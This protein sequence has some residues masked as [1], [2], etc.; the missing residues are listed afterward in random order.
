MSLFFIGDLNVLKNKRLSSIDKIVYFTLV[1]YMSRET[2]KCYPRYA[3]IKKDTGISY[4]S[5]QRSVQNLAKQKLLT[6]K[7]LS[8]TNLYLLTEQMGVEKIRRERV[9]YHRDKTELSH[10]QVL[11]KPNIYNHNRFNKRNNYNR[12][13]SS[14]PTAN[15]SKTT[16]EYQGEQYEYCGE[17]GNYIE[18][19]NKSGAKVAKHKWKDEPI[20]K[21]DASIKEA[22]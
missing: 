2:G 16:I 15:H 14:P 5:I 17:F 8:S 6:I 9:S 21:F 3:T 22:I 18:Y 10:R 19:R 20:K 12:A 4:S 11:I 1:S 7:R 13:I